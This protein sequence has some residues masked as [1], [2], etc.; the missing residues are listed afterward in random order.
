MHFVVSW[1]IAAT[2]EEWSRINTELQTVLKP[3]SW[4]RPLTTFY[5]VNVGSLETWNKILKD[6]QVVAKRQP[7]KIDL[8]LTPLMLA[9]RYDGLLSEQM[10]NEINARSK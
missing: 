9:G 5:I 6:L 8:L 3:Y 1:D 10:W 7:H 2:G 4:A